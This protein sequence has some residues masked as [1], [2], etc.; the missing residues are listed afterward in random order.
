MDNE[1]WNEKLK[2]KR[3]IIS[4]LRNKWLLLLPVCAILPRRSISAGMDYVPNIGVYQKSRFIETSS[5]TLATSGRRFQR[6]YKVYIS[7]IDIEI[8][9][10]CGNLRLS[11]CVTP[12]VNMVANIK[13]SDPIISHAPHLPRGHRITRMGDIPWVICQIK[14]EKKDN[15]RT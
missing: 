8:L 10:W 9:S 15:I 4:H 14:Q 5:K 11:N 13:V 12:M 6:L 3:R 1:K 7:L 2:N